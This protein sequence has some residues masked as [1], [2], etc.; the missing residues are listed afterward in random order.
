L[1][2]ATDEVTNRDVGAFGAGTLTNELT[3]E[4]PEPVVH[5]QQLNA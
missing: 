3:S 4:A 5:F 1:E 2:A